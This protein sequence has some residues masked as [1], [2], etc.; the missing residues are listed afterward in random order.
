MR[1]LLGILV[2]LCVS[3]TY[4]Q[5]DTNVKY[6]KDG[7]LTI[8]TYYYENGVVQQKGAFDAN[9]KLHGTWTSY[10]IKG[11]KIAVGNYENGNKV[12]KWFFWSNNSLKEVDY[13]NSKIVSV[14]EWKGKTKLAIRDK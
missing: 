4:A 13:I 14:S 1:K 2:M 11:N 8:A 12:G 5:K 7:E 6:E 3:F 9:G 10:D